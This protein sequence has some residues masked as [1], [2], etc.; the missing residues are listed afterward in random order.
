M[1]I[2]T[3]SMIGLGAVGCAV[4]PELIRLLPRESLRI[5]AGGARKARLE[6]QGVVVNGEHYD[7]FVTDPE[8]DCGPADLVIVSVK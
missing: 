8:A 7:C 4:A 5:V 6:R 1:K 3:V 2:K